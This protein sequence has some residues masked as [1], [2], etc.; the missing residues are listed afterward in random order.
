[1]P[2][3]LGQGAF[4]PRAALGWS[5][6]VC[7]GAAGRPGEPGC[8]LALAQCLADSPN[9]NG[10]CEL[11]SLPSPFLLPG[12]PTLLQMGHYSLSC[13]NIL[14]QATMFNVTPLP[15]AAPHN[16]DRFCRLALG[17]LFHFPSF[18]TPC[19]LGGHFPIAVEFLPSHSH[20]IVT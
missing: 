18:P 14:H 6:E 5:P 3:G 2:D 9:G 4:S 20:S 19:S 8:S 17:G 11:L 7:S 12:Y 10:V 15:I 16:I 1:M 13:V